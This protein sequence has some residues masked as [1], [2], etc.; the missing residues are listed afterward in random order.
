[1]LELP[2]SDRT[3]RVRMVDTTTLMTVDTGF[4][5]QPVQPGHET[6]NLTDVAFLIEHEESNQKVMFDLGTRKDYWNLPP[7]VRQPFDQAMKSARVDK[8]V[9][10]ILCEKGIELRDIGSVIWSHYHWD[11]IGNVA[12][13]PI[14][15]SLVV[16]PGFKSH[17]HLMPGFPDDA[18]SPVSADAF[19]GRDVVEP[20][21][22]DGL[23]IGGFR[24]QDF[25]GDGSFYLL[26]TPG[27]CVGHLC[28]LART[29]ADTFVFLGGD[30]CHFSGVIRPN[31]RLPF[32]ETIPS[33]VLDKDPF[34]PSP[35]PCSIFTN[36]HPIAKVDPR[37][38]PFYE[39]SGYEGSAF[40]DP[41]LAQKSVT[42]LMDFEASDNVLICIA[43]DTDLL[44]HLP[45]LNDSPSSDLN[46]WKEKGWKERLRWGWVNELPRAGRPGRKP[47]VE[48]YWRDGIF[49]KFALPRTT[50]QPHGERI[51]HFAKIIPF[52]TSS[53]VPSR[54]SLTYRSNSFHHTCQ[55]FIL[56]FACIRI[57]LNIT[58]TMSSRSALP[59]FIHD[60]MSS[61]QYSDLKIQCGGEELQVHRA[62]VCPQSE[63]LSD[64]CK[65]LSEDA[66]DAVVQVEGHDVAAVRFMIDFLYS[67]D[68]AIPD[69]A[70]AISE[71]IEDFCQ[72]DV[73]KTFIQDELSRRVITAM[74]GR[75]EWIH[76]QLMVTQECLASADEKVAKLE[77]EIE[78]LQRKV[79]RIEAGI[80]QGH[81]LLHNTPN[82]R[83]CGKMF[84]AKLECRG[85]ME[86]G[87]VLRC[88]Q[89]RTKH[90]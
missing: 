14:S 43:H 38:E 86:N 4:L 15:T 40:F 75:Y 55:S 35:C 37:Q 84:L 51:V 63:I 74:K 5:I 12:L 18:E 39:V 82:C 33:G 53:S 41:A 81:N 11:H 22:A 48:G 65:D 20:D 24:A 23:T 19:V 54:L 13:F 80:E 47:L 36:S 10:E 29:T 73:L 8:D 1:M 56:G 3:V 79:S 66:P 61:E 45:T 72:E 17:P 78:R 7:A 34:F 49:M 57:Y 44:L 62:I 6:L 69:Q 88:A 76:P 70:K 85:A 89:C 90:K 64:K 59:P 83:H 77:A 21:F 30:I 58:T 31:A 52:P 25:F 9:T 50:N 42:K 67:G 16:G 60:L 68:Y 2:K 28:G 71:H 46:S 27:H 26:D 87:Y 32:P